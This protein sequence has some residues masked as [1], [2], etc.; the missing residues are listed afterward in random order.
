MF[1][2]VLFF[3][4]AFK[5]ITIHL[6]ELL[7]KYMPKDVMKMDRCQ[8]PAGRKANSAQLCMM[9]LKSCR[10]KNSALVAMTIA[11]STNTQPDISQV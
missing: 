8:I 7:D 2:W 3:V 1:G 10:H 9:L 4:A 11:T 5:H 6:E